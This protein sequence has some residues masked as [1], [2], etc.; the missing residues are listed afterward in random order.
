M[1]ILSGFV[2][3]GIFLCFFLLMGAVLFLFDF[4]NYEATKVELLEGSLRASMKGTL[5]R[6]TDNSISLANLLKKC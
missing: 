2:S 6:T 1:I 4:S 5:P 3:L